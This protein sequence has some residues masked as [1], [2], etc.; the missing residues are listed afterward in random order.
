MG[1][2]SL[3]E[4]TSVSKTYRRRGETVH[5]L[6]AVSF[7]AQFGEF[8]CLLG[9]SGCGKSTLL[10]I[11][12]GLEHAD[13]GEVRM[14]GEPITECHPEAS[15]V[16]QEHGLFPWM[17]VERNVEFNMKARGVGKTERG[18]VAH[19]FID[20]VGLAGFEQRYPHELSGGMRQRV[21]IARALTTRP[22]LL[23]MDEPF[24][25][26][27]AQTR[28][29]MQSQLLE[30]WQAYRATVGVVTHSVDEAVFLAD[31]SV[32]MSPRPGRVRS[33]VPVDLPRPRDRA[34]P[35][36][37]QCVGEVLALIHDDLRQLVGA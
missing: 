24:G 10:Q 34:D 8:I 25:A 3:L 14:E 35:R 23:L 36:F 31:R 6:D 21:G 12:A 33:I 18:R 13:G 28:S 22:R 29:V 7:S 20:R 4:L 15:V 2:M 17:T 27:D 9:V 19:D 5:A 32:I 30:L 37:G 1:G 11:L 16:F 26:L